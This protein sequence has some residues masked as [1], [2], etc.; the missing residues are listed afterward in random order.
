MAH[1]IVS[2]HCR[3]P[4]AISPSM[5][6]AMTASQLSHDVATV[7]MHL[8]LE[9]YPIVVT[10]LAL[11]PHSDILDSDSD[12]EGGD[13]GFVLADVDKYQV[14]KVLVSRSTTWGEFIINMLYTFDLDLD[15]RKIPGGH[16][17]NMT[18]EQAFGWTRWHQWDALNRRW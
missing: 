16:L 5:S 8:Q 17:S 1:P 12:Y 3:A 2:K 18:E 6:S 4:V 10:V 11:R 14:T 15:A 9:L 7:S 13:G